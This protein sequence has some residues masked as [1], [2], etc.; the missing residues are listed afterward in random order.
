VSQ[1]DDMKSSSATNPH[2]RALWLIAALTAWMADMA[3]GAD[4]SGPGDRAPPVAP[5]VA[6]MYDRIVFSRG[7]PSGSKTIWSL[8]SMA[9]DGTDLRPPCWRDSIIRS[10][11]I[12]HRMGVRSCLRIG[13]R[14]S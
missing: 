7:T 12:L 6:P 11:P 9:T 13:A 4:S 5:P 2:G 8:W 10:L 3:C 1:A 14:F